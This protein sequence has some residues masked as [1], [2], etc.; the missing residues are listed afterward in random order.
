MMQQRPEPKGDIKPLWDLLGVKFNADDVIW[1]DYEP[2]PKVEIPY[3]EFVFVDKG[4]DRDS[5][6]FSAKDP[7]SSG[8]Q[9]LLF[10]FPGSISG[11][12][13]STM[14]FESLVETGTK[15]GTAEVQQIA[16]MLMFGMMQIDD[17]GKLTPTGRPYTLAARIQGELPAP[18]ETDA[19]EGE[20]DE[21]KEDSEKKTPEAK[22]LNVILVAD[23]DM[24]HHQFFLLRERGNNPEEGFDLRFDNVPF[25]LNILDSLA[26][27]DRF[28]EIR[29][30]R[31]VHRTLTAIERATE[32]SR[33]HSTQ[34]AKRLQDEFDEFVK[35]EQKKLDD[36]VKALEE[37]MKSKDIRS[38]D[39]LIQ[40]SLEQETRQKR[41]D[42]EKDRLKAKMQQEQDQIDT[43]MNAEIERVRRIYK[44]CAVALPPILPLL[45]AVF[46]FISRR[47][48]EQEGVARSRLR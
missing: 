38:Q 6:P 17:E 20:Q 27:D 4:Q 35:V 14:S 34:E 39:V 48:Q 21:S 11:L 8:L 40:A 24:L 45:I 13:A 12:N 30:R 43:K 22:K 32:D 42:A 5:T 10:V 15:T 1:Q 25:V 37:Q 2:Y 28:V 41:L 3:K 46:V 7:V 26:G 33:K 47:M 9:Q 19:K 16:P 18:A 29:K 36:K 31:P 44:I 23:I